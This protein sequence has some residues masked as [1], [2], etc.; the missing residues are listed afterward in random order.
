MPRVFFTL[1]LVV[2]AVITAGA[3]QPS[4]AKD[5]PDPQPQQEPVITDPAENAA[6][7]AAISTNLEHLQ[8]ALE[9]FLERFP[10]SVMRER[11]EDGLMRLMVY[12]DNES[13]RRIR[14]ELRFREL[15]AANSAKAAAADGLSHYV[16]CDFSPF[17]VEESAERDQYFTRTVTT[18]EGEHTIEV[19]HGYS[20]HIAYKETPFVNFKAEKVG[21]SASDPKYLKN[22]QT[23]IENLKYLSSGPGSEMA[24]PWP[25][26]LNGFEVYAINRK[27]MEGGVLS[28]YLLFRDPD[29]AAITLYMLNTPPES[30]QFRT[31]EE[32]R[33][34]RD[35]FL[36]TYTACTGTHAGTARNGHTATPAQNP[37]KTL[38]K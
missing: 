38:K 21:Q 32:Y 22:K 36:N 25:S 9:N 11:I 15:A 13:T 8:P 10:N 3:Q 26:L 16:Q 12:R 33:A 30:P 7:M 31:L 35:R 28:I 18:V 5:P 1:L 4:N 19:F 2:G 37:E 24:Q 17:R 34:L 6:Y 14:A 20:L 27:Q 23:L 29:Q